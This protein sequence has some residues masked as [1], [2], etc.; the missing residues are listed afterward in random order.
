MTFLIGTDEAGYGPNL[1]PLVISATAWHVPD[2][3]DFP[4]LFT[5]LADC[6]AREPMRNG[7]RH[8]PMA[9]SKTLYSSGATLANLEMGVFA[10]LAAVGLIPRSWK[11]IWAV[12]DAASETCITADPWFRNYQESLPV[13]LDAMQ[14]ECGTDALAIGLQAAQVS[15]RKMRS[16]V[17]FPEEFNELCERH[18]NNKGAALSALTL[19]LVRDM[20]ADADDCRI[21]VQCDKH[22]GRN[23]YCAL[24]QHYFPDDLIEVRKEGREESIYRCG[25][26]TRRVEFRFVAKG[27]SFLPSALASMISKYL[28]ELAMRAFN[29]FWCTQIP[30]L[31]PT[32]GYPTDAV[33][34]KAEILSLQKE[35]GFSDRVLWRNR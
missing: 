14:L 27:E 26:T 12:L 15:L 25:P 17:V 30:N 19:E 28:R 29:H 2:E 6:I 10:S 21:L 23:K 9:D 7:T 11:E 13:D 1:G 24:L 4:D 16:R 32:A 20:L 33:R 34:F 35:L 18:G 31:K 8:V 3:R 5:V 22:G